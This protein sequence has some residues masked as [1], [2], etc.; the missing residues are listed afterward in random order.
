MSRV[1]RVWFVAAG[2]G[3]IALLSACSTSPTEQ[4]AISAGAVQVDASME[5]IHNLLL[6]DSGLLIGSHQGLWLQ[7]GTNPAERIGKS[8]F[9]V[10]GLASTATGLVSSGHPGEGEEQVSNL[11]LRA[12]ADQGKTWQN[13]SLFGEVDFHRLVASGTTIMGIV[14]ADGAL[15]RST[16]SGKTWQTVPSPSLYDIAIDP[17]D[18]SMVVGT[19]ENGPVLSMDGAKTFTAIPD[20]PLLALLSWGE[21]RL[22][23]VT[24]EG[25]IFES[26]DMGLTWKKI[27]TVSGQ[28]GA[29]AVRGDE[30]A[31]LSGT[32]VFYSSDAGLT[33]KERITGVMGH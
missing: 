20:A 13:L 10:M 11:G 32:T 15:L 19:T 5:H 7:E 2:V 12:S 24:S 25:V 3:L 31:L 18:P 23:G 6:T 8:H 26:R 30:I 29:I 9:D 27:A 16:D 33:F 21:S 22:I 17:M 1:S 28:P 4:D 14:S